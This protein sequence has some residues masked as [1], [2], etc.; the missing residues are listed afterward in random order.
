MNERKGDL[1]MMIEAW[2]AGTLIQPI[3]CWLSFGVTGAMFEHS[4]EANTTSYFLIF[5]HLNY[6]SL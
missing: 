1:E 3:K 4:L 2:P 5:I 6:Y